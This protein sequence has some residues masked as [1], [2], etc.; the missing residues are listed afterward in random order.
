MERLIR[1]LKSRRAE[2]QAAEIVATGL[3]YGIAGARGTE[4]LSVARRLNDKTLHRLLTDNPTPAA[5]VC[6]ERELRRREAYP[7]FRIAVLALAISAVS[8]LVSI[9][10]GSE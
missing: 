4:S 1:Y 2:A 3:N 9:L 10:N 7:T 5:K 8:L 6:L